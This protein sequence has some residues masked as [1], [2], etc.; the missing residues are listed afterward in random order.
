MK[1]WSIGVAAAVVVAAIIGASYLT[2]PVLAAVLCA[3]SVLIGIG[4]PRL[5]GLPTA[6]S[7]G[8][9][10]ALAGI[11]AV[12]VA[13]LA[14]ARM[15]MEW[16]PVVIALGVI[17]V[18]VVQLLRG[19]G[20]K[21]RL[22]STLGA[23]AGVLLAVMAS[24]WVGSERLGSNAGNSSMTLVTGI[25]SLAA[26]LVC[27]LPW[28]DRIVAPLGFVAAAVTGPLAGMLFGDVAPWSVVVVGAVCGAVIV[29]FRRLV[30]AGPAVRGRLG[31]IAFGVAPI[32]A[33]GAL[34]YLLDRLLLV[35]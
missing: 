29:S 5:L 34:V 7:L 19:T 1:S 21:L 33:L 30:L 11:A 15:A 35:S 20:A 32:A 31:S 25:S 3:A 26:I 2:L 17:G 22:D 4:W 24:G 8:T 18:F 13:W 28:P 23:S 16:P 6:R 12:L 27:L 10:I 9:L 14:P